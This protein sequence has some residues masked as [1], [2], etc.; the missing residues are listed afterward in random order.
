MKTSVAKFFTEK[1]P[2][3]NRVLQSVIGTR[4][5]FEPSEIQSR[6]VI[7]KLLATED[8]QRLIAFF[9]NEFDLDV[10]SEPSISTT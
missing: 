10:N 2:Q 7:G 6:S 5:V 9:I 8:D 1:Y 3:I 4:S